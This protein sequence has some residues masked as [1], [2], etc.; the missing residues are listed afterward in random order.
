VILLIIFKIPLAVTTVLLLCID[1]GTDMFP[2]ISFAYEDAEL[3]IMTKRPRDRHEHLVSK[4][5]LAFSYL[6]I[7]FL[8]SFGAFLTYF[9]V[10]SNF[11]FPMPTL[12]GLA[13]KPG[14]KH[15]DSDVYDPYHPT[16]GNSNILGACIGQQDKLSDGS[17][18]SYLPDWIF[19]EDIATDGRMIYVQ[20]A[21][22]NG[23]LTGGVESSVSFGPCGAKEI[24]GQT[25][26]PVCWS[27]DS[28]KSAQ[29]S[30]LFSVVLLQWGNAIANK[31]R[32]TS[33]YFHG[34][35]NYFLLFGLVTE[36]IFCLLLSYIPEIN[37]ALGTRPLD[38]L[39][40]GAPAL[41]FT[42]LILWYDEIRKILMGRSLKGIPDGGKPGWWYR[43]YGW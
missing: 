8:E 4:K 34:T 1:L 40:F 26:R 29:T 2:S 11:G 41:C 20:C 42:C 31:T 28:I 21:R 36:T 12:L 7:G 35:K 39:H 6:Q 17:F 27:I 10:M 16:F 37:Q 5:L 33:V 3:D 23:V 18:S 25:H 15:A 22:N 24:S 43:N 30:Y 32:R 38:F 14:F 19:N 13:L 9:V